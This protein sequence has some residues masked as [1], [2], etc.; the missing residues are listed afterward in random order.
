MITSKHRRLIIL[1]ISALFGLLS[2]LSLPAWSN[3]QSNQ[4]LQLA[5]QGQ[6]S[7]N[8]GN[9]DQAIQ[10]WQAAAKAY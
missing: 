2:S 9:F 5:Q 7:Y 10:L 6:Q 8:A 3:S 1:L 4:A